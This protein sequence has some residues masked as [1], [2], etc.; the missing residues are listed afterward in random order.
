MRELLV[1]PMPTLVR[2]HCCRDEDPARVGHGVK[3]DTFLLGAAVAGG[4]WE[5]KVDDGHH[6][7]D[8]GFFLL[9]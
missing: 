9:V 6:G 1:H 3:E 7:L 8:A 2:D 5:E 4:G